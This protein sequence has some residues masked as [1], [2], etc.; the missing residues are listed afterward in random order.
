MPTRLCSCCRSIEM[1]QPAYPWDLVL[2]GE[3]A[4]VKCPQGKTCDAGLHAGVRMDAGTVLAGRYPGWL[5]HEPCQAGC[6]GTAPVPGNDSC[7]GHAGAGVVGVPDFS[8]ATRCA[9]LQSIVG[10]GARVCTELAGST[11]QARAAAAAGGSNA[12][13]PSRCC[14]QTGVEVGCCCCLVLHLQVLGV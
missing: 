4:S 7:A 11:R 1:R 5:S 8:R 9:S 13:V 2:T 12:C 3:E 14:M 6:M 10:L